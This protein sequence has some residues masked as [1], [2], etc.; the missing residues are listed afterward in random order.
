MTTYQEISA[1]FYSNRLLFGDPADPGVVA[2]EVA[3]KTEIDVYRRLSG[4]LTRER[5]PIRLFALVENASILEGFKAPHETRVLDGDFRYRVLVT[6][7]SIDSLEAA[8][9]HLRNETGKPPNAPDAPYL[10]LADPIE[11]H[12]MLTGTTFFIG[13]DFAEL[14]RLQLD[15]ETYISPGFEF[16]SAAREGDRVIAISLTDSTGFECLLKGTEMDERA[17]LEEMV[18]IVRNAIP[19]SSRVTICFASISNT[20][21]RAR[22]AI[23][24]R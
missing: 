22:A 12:L 9:R 24:C 16:P 21:R 6:F 14:R 20:S 5:R 1:Q 18:R 8:R 2:V 23:A 10:V 13:M 4:R 11:Q 3:S 17:M 7:A 19:T 15:I